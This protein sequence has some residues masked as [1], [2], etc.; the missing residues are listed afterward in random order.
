[1][2]YIVTLINFG[3]R[4]Y[5][6]MNILDAIEAAQNAGFEASL[7]AIHNGQIIEHAVYSPINGWS[8]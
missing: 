3:S 6:G 5:D 7:I 1:M 8:E 4:I 2:K